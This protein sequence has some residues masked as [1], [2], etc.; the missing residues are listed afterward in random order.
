MQ[1]LE[2]LEFNNH[3][4]ERFAFYLLLKTKENESQLFHKHG[5]ISKIALEMI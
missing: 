4:S 3:F 2:G 1:V 5:T